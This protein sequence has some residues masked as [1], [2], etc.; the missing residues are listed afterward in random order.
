SAIRRRAVKTWKHDGLFVNGKR[1]ELPAAAEVLELF[2][3][4]LVNRRR[5]VRQK[6]S[7][8]QL[9]RERQGLGRQR[10]GLACDLAGNGARRVP[11]LFHRQKR[12][13][14]SGARRS[15]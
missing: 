11:P 9:T 8:Q 3:R 7:G 2:E 4:P 12:V 6:V 1:Q 14:L 5:A 13:A 10:L 15:T